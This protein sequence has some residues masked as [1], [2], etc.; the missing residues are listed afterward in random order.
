MEELREFKFSAKSKKKSSNSLSDFFDEYYSDENATYLTW[1]TLSELNNDRFEVQRSTDGENFETIHIVKGQGTT[2]METEYVSVDTKPNIGMNYYR[3]KQVDHNG[4]TRMSE[5]RTINILDDF[6][7]ILA[8]SPNPTT[9]ETEVI[10]NSYRKENVQLQVLSVEGKQ[11]VNM[12]LPAVPGG[13][14]F[15]LDLTEVEGNVF[16]VTITTSSKTYSGKVVK[17]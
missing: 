14:R 11:V 5:I 1:K 13:N 16:F 15:D 2:S 9:G 6:Y 8:F 10:F 4:A 17:R 3:L 12:E 7:D